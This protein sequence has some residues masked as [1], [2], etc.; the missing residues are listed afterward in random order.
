MKQGMDSTLIRDLQL[1]DLES[2]LLI[3]HVCFPLPRSREMLS[4]ELE[5]ADTS[6]FGVFLAEEL[7]AYCSFLLVLDEM[8][9]LRLCTNPT[10]R[11]SGL[12]RTLLRELV[13]RG[14]VIRAHQILLEVAAN[15][16]EAI[17]LY[18]SFDFKLIGRRAGYYAY[19]GQDALL[20]SLFLNNSSN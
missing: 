17:E 12:A 13:A 5:S 2:L 9:L 18:R 4:G 3:E 11:R 6:I 14:N 20:Y 16:Y 8:H 10:H 7:L 1:E 15:N 19:E